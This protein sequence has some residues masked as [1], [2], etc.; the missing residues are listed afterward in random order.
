MAS[1]TRLKN[2]TGT[3]MWALHKS[4]NPDDFRCTEAWEVSDLP[5]VLSEDSIEP[6]IFPLDSRLLPLNSFSSSNV[7]E[8]VDS[9]AMSSE[10]FRDS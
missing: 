10:L 6:A 1:A 8:H 4:S 5:H 9:D 7:S 3:N 2:K